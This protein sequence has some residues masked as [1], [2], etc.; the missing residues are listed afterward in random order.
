MDGEVTL[1]TGVAGFLGSA[2]ARA[3]AASGRT[4]RGVVRASSPRANLADFPGA[5]V[6]ADLRD[7]AAVR[8][9]MHGV[10]EVFHVAADYRLWAKDP[11]EIV[12]NN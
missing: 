6:A 5:L 7:P 10:G 4:V 2:V 12:R 9:A 1:V 3:L 8:A 11:E